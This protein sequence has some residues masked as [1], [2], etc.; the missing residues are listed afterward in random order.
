M[1]IYWAETNCLQKNNELLLDATEKNGNKVNAEK[2]QHMFI[3]FEGNVEEYHNLK[4]SNTYLCG[5]IPKK[6]KLFS[7]IN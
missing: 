5:H 4:E 3:S 2:P 7:Q 1:I 6:S